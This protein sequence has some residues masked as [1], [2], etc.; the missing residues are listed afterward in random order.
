[1]LGRLGEGAT[2][3]VC[4]MLMLVCIKM[5]TSWRVGQ[6]PTWSTC[7]Y[8]CTS[9]YGA[10]RREECVP[11]QGG[12]YEHAS[13]CLCAGRGEE[14]VLTKGGPYVHVSERLYAGR[15]GEGV[16][17]QGGHYVHVSRMRPCGDGGLLQCGP[18]VLVHISVRCGGVTASP[19]PLGEGH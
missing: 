13:M 19:V 10:S 16:P 18:Y 6:A 4:P 2:I 7:T 17:I 11:N 5:G 3:H 12:P 14:G 15:E 9:V 1:M 8:K